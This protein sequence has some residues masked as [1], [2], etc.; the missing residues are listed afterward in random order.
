[1][2]RLPDCSTLSIA[3]SC[4]LFI[5]LVLPTTG[6]CQS[7]SL[8]PDNR[9]LNR[10]GLE[11]AWWGHAVIDPA[12]DTIQY[13]RVD[14]DNIYMQSRSGLVTAFD[15]ETGRRLWSSLLGASTLESLPVSTNESELLIP[16][17]LRLIAV[18][19]FTGE[20]GWELEL[21]GQPSTS[22]AVAKN[23]IY[24]GMVDGSIYAYDLRKIRVLFSENRLP[25][26]S[27][28]A[29]LWRYTAAKA[30]TSTPI[31]RND[32]VTFSSLNGSVYSV[33][34]IE[35]GLNFEFETDG[36][37]RTQ[38]SHGSDSIYV[39]SE[40]ARLFC[41]N[42]DNGVR[43]WAFTAGV[44]IRRQ[45]RV[46]GGDVFVTPLRDGMY[47]LNTVTGIIKWHQ[48]EADTFLAATDDHVYA[49]DFVGNLLMLSRNGDGAVLGLLPYRQLSLRVQNDRTDR[50]YLGTES[51][52]IVC[53][54]ERGHSFPRFHM[55]PDRS[56]ILPEMAPDDETPE[57]SGG[58]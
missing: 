12:R 34:A 40:D 28:V 2:K 10:Y 36:E 11:R 33:E 5:I 52:L 32:T 26:W 7:S 29:L 4:L 9:E 51:G 23:Y 13:V 22:P 8:L 55:Y 56:P 38:I 16:V 37:I 45:P 18:D 48:P 50:I 49:S 24:I 53:L 19:K 1:M 54:R 21:P 25:N 43:R 47:C 27:N 17:G 41:L 20:P 44:P 15:A 39:A 31:I 42:A 14:E 46:I 3:G 30:V 58:N 57:A 35:R 6:F